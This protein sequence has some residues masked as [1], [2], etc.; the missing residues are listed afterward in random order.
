MNDIDSNAKLNNDSKLESNNSDNNKIFKNIIIV[1]ISNIIKLFSGVLIGFIIPKIMGENNYG[2]YKTYTLYLDYVGLFS[3]GFVDGIY[4]L[5][6]GKKYD[7]FIR[8]SFRTYSKF[9]FLFQFFITLIIG[10]VS[11]FFIHNY[12]GFIFLF[13]AFT[14][15]G[16]NISGYFQQISQV[17]GRFKEL[18]FRNLIQAI[19]QALSVIICFLLWYTNVISELH[20]KVYV[21]ISTILINLLA[22]WYILTY[23]DIVFGQSNKISDEKD[24]I[25]KFFRVGFPLMIA[26]IITSLI[27]TIDKQFVSILTA[28][29]VYTMSDFGV[30]SFAYTMLNIITTIISAISIVLYPTI[31]LYSIEK[32][33]SSYSKL[34]AIISII[35]SM[36]LLSYQ[37]LCFIVTKWLPDYKNSLPIF[38]IILPGVVISSC[39][40]MIMFNYYKA[41]GKHL[42]FFLLSIMALILSLIGD[43][44]AYLVDGNMSSISIAS[45]IVMCIWYIIS[46]FYLF[47]KLRINSIINIG[48]VMSI[49]LSF[50]L[51]NNLIKNIYIGFLTY[52]FS[53]AITTIIFYWKYIIKKFKGI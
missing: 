16:N 49:C 26:N 44:I 25:I 43:F 9:Y 34:I 18:S 13:V 39:V 38:K 21:I 1:A 48:Y 41:I 36:C 30:Y 29:G 14:L 5:Y 20:F 33:Q 53:F 37:P 50:Y 52:L 11:L 45:I 23:R 3:L 15:L 35:T 22:I 32:L 24:M 47:K 7:S 17:T 42:M 12:Y 27:L 10:C 19:L 4:L 28:N 6:A 2:Y 51:I 40:T 46:E 31:K 8:I